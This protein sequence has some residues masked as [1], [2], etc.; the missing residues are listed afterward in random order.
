MQLQIR[1]AGAAALTCDIRD[2][3]R[4]S[5]SKLH[6]I[7][8][9]RILAYKPYFRKLRRSDLFKPPRAG[10][11]LSPRHDLLGI[12]RSLYTLSSRPPSAVK[13]QPQYSARRAVATSLAFAAVPARARSSSKLSSGSLH[14]RN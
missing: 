10:S 5:V 11:C 9:P 12:C 13:S 1:A 14:Q 4:A 7:S 6:T 3:G 2:A 8:D